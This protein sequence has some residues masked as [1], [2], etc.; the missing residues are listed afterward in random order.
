MKLNIFTIFDAATQ[1]YIQPFFSMT[2]E[3]AQ[4]SFGQAI[5]D[6]RHDFH[7][8]A[9]DYTLFHCGEFDQA[10]GKFILFDAPQA[11]EN[12]LIH[13]RPVTP[14]IS[15]NQEAEGRLARAADETPADAAPA[16]VAGK[17]K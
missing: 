14:P 17:G 13:L 16:V 2:V 6:E 4:R 10:E 12:A 8:F 9:K 11:L 15:I 5:N 1:Q 7:N 3:S